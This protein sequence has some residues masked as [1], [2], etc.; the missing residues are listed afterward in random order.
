MLTMDRFLILKLAF[1]IGIID[2]RLLPHQTKFKKKSKFFNRLKIILL[3][4]L[5]NL[6]VQS[7]LSSNVNYQIHLFLFFA[8]YV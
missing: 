7:I 6:G 3:V 5:I 4:I 2:L 1:L 8:V